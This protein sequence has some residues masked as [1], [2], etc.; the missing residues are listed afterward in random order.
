MRGAARSLRGT[1]SAAAF[2]AAV[3]VLAAAGAVHAATPFVLAQESLIEDPEVAVDE[4][5]VG[6]FVWSAGNGIRYCQVPR[7]GTSCTNAQTFG[8]SGGPARILLPGGERILLL[9][10]TFDVAVRESLDGGLTWSQPRVIG[11]VEPGGDAEL[12]PGDFS[13]SLIDDGRY[14]AAPLDRRT[15]ASAQLAQ[16]PYTQG[17][18][19]AFADPV[20][21]I[22][23]FHGSERTSVESQIY[24][25]KWSG[26]GDYNDV[27]SWDPAQH[28]G[29]GEDTR[30]VGGKRGVFM[31]H[32]TATR[33]ILND[34]HY[35]IARWGGM[36]FGDSQQITPTGTVVASDL[37]QDRAGTIHFLWSDRAD[38]TL[39]HRVSADG[40]SWRASEALTRGGDYNKLQHAAARDGGGFAVYESVA[41]GRRI[42]A[43]PFGPRGAVTEPGEDQDD[44]SCPPEL[45]VGAAKVIARE[46]CLQ[47]TAGT[48]R[49]TTN[50][51]VRVSGIDLE[52]GRRTTVLIQRG[53]RTLTTSGPVQAKAGNII[54]DKKKIEWKLPP[55]GG[56]ITDLVGNPATFD[57]AKYAVAFLGLKV[58]GNT[59]PELLPGGGVKIPIHLELPQP[60]GGLAGIGKAT[61]DLDLKAH[62]ETGL[63]LS[64]LVVH[65]EDIALGI[66]QVEKLDLVYVGDPSRLWT[67]ANLIL[68]VIRSELLT[69]FQITQGRFDYGKGTLEFPELGLPLAAE[70]YLKSIGFSIETDPRRL[71]GTARLHAGSLFAQP[72]FTLDTSISYTFPDAPNPGVF[73][74]EGRG[75]MGDI[76]VGDAFVEYVVGRRIAF[77]AKVALGDTSAGIRGEV[78]GALDVRTRAFDLHGEAE[79]CAFGGCAG[80]EVLVSTKAIAGCLGSDWVGLGA[81]YVWKEGLEAFFHCDLEEYRAVTSAR[82]SQDG[83]RIVQIPAGLPLAGIQVA[84]E[85]APPRVTVSGPQGQTIATPADQSQPVKTE[86]GVLVADP[87]QN[88]T[89]VNLRRPAGGAWTITAQPESAPVTAVRQAD[90]LP[91]P[92][93]SAVVRGKGRRRTLSYRVR[94]IAGQT[95]RLVEEGGGAYQE[96]ATLRRA[97]GRLRFTPANGKRGKRQIVALVEQDGLP[98]DRLLAGGYAAPGPIVPARPARVRLIRRG[99]KLVV[100]WRRAR[101][102]ASYIVQA[103][104][105]D[106]RRLTIPTRS[107]RVRI[108]EVAGIDAGRIRVYGSRPDGTIGKPGKA[109]L[110][111]KIKKRKRRR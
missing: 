102:A 84:G 96:L 100:T 106:G 44:A 67:R 11:S 83:A 55:D 28:Y 81:A 23:A 9:S 86:V 39:R 63:E 103:R 80:G 104:L 79:L 29:A 37:F 108:D 66:A 10:G 101:H 56:A 85:G 94:Q 3:V 61:G 35:R 65:A 36:G 42:M 15:D 12:G 93:V 38:G 91:K 82:A 16:H 59:K 54:L 47:R 74:A 111:R 33:G 8:G 26:A 49:Y 6:H 31:S 19:V 60:F 27:A 107:S 71:M 25:R 14:Q 50:G 110:K 97:R 34:S 73:R 78:D 92:R 53:E 41:G 89:V 87:A 76:P 69:E 90:G 109:K 32:R 95:V 4:N 99:G 68:P 30:L 77:G 46:G 75:S 7:N 5:G 20:T 17:S 105:S 24:F 57:V 48:Q 88:V 72:L 22:A 58:S 51:D 98:R 70:V 21:P 45:T 13:V 2:A 52:V 62:A 43:V 40:R 1:A 64:N 18:D